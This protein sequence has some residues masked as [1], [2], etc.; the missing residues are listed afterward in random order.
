MK[1]SV[2]W[3]ADASDEFFELWS[4]TDR[5][6]GVVAAADKIDASLRSKPL[7]VGE[8]RSDNRR[9]YFESPLAIVYEVF[10]TERRVNILRVRYYAKR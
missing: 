5:R 10:V 7:D 8:S 6:H 4:D 3:S 9:I 2:T 1:F